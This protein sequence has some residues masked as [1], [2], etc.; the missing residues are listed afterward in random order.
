M[1]IQEGFLRELRLCDY[2]QLVTPSEVAIAVR[3]DI[4]I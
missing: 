3:I 1:V 2:I 4:T